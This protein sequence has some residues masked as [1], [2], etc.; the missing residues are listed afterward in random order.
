MSKKTPDVMTLDEVADYLR[1]PRS[2]VYKLAREGRI[3]GQKIGRQ[4]RFRRAVVEHW[5]GDTE[6][7]QRRKTQEQQG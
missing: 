6:S 5:L 2:T 4:W 7:Q 3:P 1:I